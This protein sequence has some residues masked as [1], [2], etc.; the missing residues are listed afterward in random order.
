M[1]YNEHAK[2]AKDMQRKIAKLREEN[3]DPSLPQNAPYKNTPVPLPVPGPSPPP[4]TGNRMV[5]SQ[6]TGD[7][8]F[9]LLGQRVSPMSSYRF[10]PTD[11]AQVGT[12]RYSLQSVLESDNRPFGKYFSA[13]CFRIRSRSIPTSSQKGN[14]LWYGARGRQRDRKPLIRFLQTPG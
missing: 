7:E 8:S 9:M 2:S 13:S 11:L 12:R 1:L 3:K 5:D 4:Q 10:V 14:R 6:N